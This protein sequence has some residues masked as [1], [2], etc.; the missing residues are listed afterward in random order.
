MI[1][2]ITK[3]IYLLCLIVIIL[4]LQLLMAKPISDTFINERVNYL[5]N[6]S[7]TSIVTT[8]KRFS[9]WRQIYGS[10]YEDDENTGGAGHGNV[11]DLENR[12]NHHFTSGY[13]V[14]CSGFVRAVIYE[15][16]GTDVMKN[17][18][19]IEN[20]VNS[21]YF[22]EISEAQIKPGDIFYTTEGS[23]GH[24]IGI[25]IEVL[26]YDANKTAT[27]RTAES[28]SGNW[29]R[30]ITKYDY[31]S[32]AGPY[33]FLRLNSN[34]TSKE[35]IQAIVNWGNYKEVNKF[36]YGEEVCKIIKG[37]IEEF[38]NT[39]FIIITVMGILI[40]ILMTALEFIKT[41]TSPEKE[42]LKIA[43]KHTIIRVLCAILLL[44]LP[45]LVSWI[46]NIVNDIGINNSNGKEGETLCEIAK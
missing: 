17:G 32:G 29:S 45:T 39:L 5:D 13:G 16:T 38:L 7:D 37:P 10:S 22:T 12:I 21:G 25:I 1:I 43:F 18:I 42:G 33:K 19:Y 3:N 20:I 8:A 14:N 4:I 34:I 24:H 27:F 9:S 35:D 23:S 11:S 15:A 31:Y 44:L 6:N 46:I 28:D 30:T 2:K 26:G 40:L 36:E 41:I